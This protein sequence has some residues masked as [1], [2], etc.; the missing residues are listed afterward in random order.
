MMRRA[1][2]V[3]LVASPLA[4][5]TPALAQKDSGELWEVTSKVT[6]DGMAMPAMPQ[7]VCRRKG[8]DNNVA[9]M[10]Q[11]CKASDYKTVGNRTTYRV[12]CT[13]KDA[14]SGTGEITRGK[15][16]YRGMMKL[17][18]KVDGDD[19]TMVTEYSGRLLGKCTPR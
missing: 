1:V 17:A 8:G 6:M 13:G 11:N 7:Q 5:S 4:L 10:D 2:L 18:G 9:P 15:G 14:M 12:V 19:A 3:V 16:T